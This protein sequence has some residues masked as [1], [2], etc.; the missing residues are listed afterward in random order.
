MK[1]RAFAALNAV[2]RPERLQTVAQFNLLERLFPGMSDCE[3]GVI[4]RMPVLRED[5]VLKQRRDAMDGL[6]NG[7]AI[8]NGKRT[9]GAEVVLHVDDDQNIV[10][11]RSASGLLSRG[12]PAALAICWFGAFR[13]QTNFT[14][15]DCL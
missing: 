13:N 5:D 10:L 4:W 2:R 6:D 8:G 3:G 9:A 7:I 12:T 14:S 11:R 1:L 15:L